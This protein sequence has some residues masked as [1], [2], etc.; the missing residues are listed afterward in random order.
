MLTMIKKGA[1]KLPVG[2]VPAFAAALDCEPALLLRLALEQS[3]GSTV[4]A[5]IYEIIGQPITKNELAW[6]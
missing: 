5:A 4:A 6:I 2:R 3:E 1:S